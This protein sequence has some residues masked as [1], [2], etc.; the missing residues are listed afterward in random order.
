MTIFSPRFRPLRTT[1]C[2]LATLVISAC[3]SRGPVLTFRE[4]DDPTADTLAD[5]SG[6]APGLHAAWGSTDARY[7]RS[8]TP[9]EV[10]PECR[11]TAWRGERVSAQLVLWSADSVGGVECRIGKFR[12]DNHTLP[13]DIGRTRFVRYVVT[14]EFGPGCGYRTDGDF[15]ISLAADML[16][17]LD[18]FDMEARTVRPVWLTVDV[19]ADAPAG[20]YRSFVE[21][22]GEGAESRRLPFE[23]RV[24]ERR[25]PEPAAWSYRLDLWQ[26]PAAVARAEGLELWSDAHFEALRS[27]VRMLSD[28]GQKV[29]T[30]TLN[31][32]PWNHQCFDAYE[33]MIR[34]TKRADGGWEYDYS[35]FDRW[36]ELCAEEGITS[37]INCYSL[38]PWNNEV[39]YFDAASGTWIEVVAD[40]AT[41][42][43]E[44]MW[45]PFLRDFEA[46]LDAKGWLEKSCI[47]MDERSPETMDA[48]IGLLRRVAPGL[49]IAM[50]DNHASYKRYPGLNDVCVQIDC[51]VADE[52]L[53]RRRR[54]QLVTTYYVCCSSEFPNTFT[55]SAPWEAVYM[56]W[57]AAACGYDGMLR[58]SYNSW[59]ADPVRDSR[60]TAWPAGDTYIVYPGARSS[61]RFERLREGIQDFEKIRI[62]RTELAE[63]TSADGTLRLAELDAAVSPFEAHDASQ[64]WPE[65]L[66]KSKQTIDRLSDW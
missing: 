8:K 55:F 39:R 28:A 57:F 26:H 44:Q 59:P 2:V 14:D 45:T 15:P 37:Q 35:L 63:D 21:V 61:I 7:P 43:F 23:L 40:P 10:L 62:L 42:A 20:L 16:D 53:I 19:P 41:P 60:F 58:W 17:T 34:W 1:A 25:L 48:A 64:P 12:S 29:V 9:A 51:R 52:D 46:H 6:V 65:I 66:H 27:Y 24:Q 3:A 56:A 47:A 36:V 33:D 30:A 50:A 5:W 54:E 13:A 31:K 38:L 11:L 22:R 32:D 49:G 18:R 4:A